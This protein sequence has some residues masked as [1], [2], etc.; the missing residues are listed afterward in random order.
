MKKGEGQFGVHRMTQEENKFTDGY[1]FKRGIS[2]FSKATKN[3]NK[4]YWQ[5]LFFSLYGIVLFCC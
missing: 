1:S 5:M 3:K 4:K 2:S